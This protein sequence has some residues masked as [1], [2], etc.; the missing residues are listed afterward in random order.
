MSLHGLA[1]EQVGK[2]VSQK[3]GNQHYFCAVLARKWG[4]EFV[5]HQLDYANGQI[6]LAVTAARVSP[7]TLPSEPPWPSAYRSAALA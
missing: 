4:Q 6:S 2:V 5:F 3:W 7:W 1:D